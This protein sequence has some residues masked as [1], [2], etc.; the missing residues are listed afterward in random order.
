MDRSVGLRAERLGQIVGLHVPAERRDLDR[1]LL[2]V[3]ERAN[4]NAS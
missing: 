2:L 3:L 4:G 1:L